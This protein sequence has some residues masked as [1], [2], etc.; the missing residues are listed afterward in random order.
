MVPN[1]VTHHIYESDFNPVSPNAPFL[2][3]YLYETVVL[4]QTSQKK[5]ALHKKWSFPSRMETSQETADLVTFTE[6]VF[7]GKL[8][9]FV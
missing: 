9:F 4:L 3:H 6:K 2:Y 5:R 1:R 8:H 7:N